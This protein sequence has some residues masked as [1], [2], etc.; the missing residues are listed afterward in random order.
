MKLCDRQKSRNQFRLLSFSFSQE[1]GPLVFP[2]ES[3]MSS[4]GNA[5]AKIRSQSGLS[6]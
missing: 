1:L 4:V 3:E 2:A 5:L 6:F